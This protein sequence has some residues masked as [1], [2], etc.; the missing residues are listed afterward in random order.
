M[1]NKKLAV[2]LGL[3]EKTEKDFNNMLADMNS[4][5][6]NNQG[7]FQGF[8][9]DFHSFEG[10]PDQPELR[11]TQMVS[12]TVREQLDW[13]KEHTKDYLS[14]VLSIEKT[15]AQGVTAPL[16]VEGDNWGEVT[17]TELL[18]LKGILDSKLKGMVDVIPIRPDGTKWTAT[19]DPEY[20][21][22]EVFE[23]TTF[24]GK[25][26]T[27]IKRTVVVDDALQREVPGITRPPVTQTIDTP[28]ETGE[29]AKQHFT[30]AWT[31]RQRAQLQVKYS[32]LYKAVVEALETANSVTLTESTLGDKVLNYLFK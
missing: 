14:I 18:R 4:K 5:F 11:K 3:R 7:L 28:T 17:T 31:N 22:R 32:T 12:S 8:R 29:F 6:K 16:I 24:M 15:N 13:L 27:T 9:Y 26:K 21:G 1:S 10:H 23:D 25:T 2:A 20:S 19:S 30:G